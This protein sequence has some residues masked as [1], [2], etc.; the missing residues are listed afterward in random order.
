LALLIEPD[1]GSVARE[2]ENDTVRR[3]NEFLK[4]MICKLFVMRLL[5]QEVIDREEVFG[6]ARQNPDI[7]VIVQIMLH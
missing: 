3:V 5:T 7:F 6:W 4:R 1:I 2:I